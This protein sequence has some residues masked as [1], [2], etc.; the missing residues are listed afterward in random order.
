[1]AYRRAD[2]WLP[3]ARQ[4][5]LGQTCPS[6]EQLM[7]ITDV[8]DPCQNPSAAAGIGPVAPNVGG[9]FTCFNSQTGTYYGCNTSG[10][11]TSVSPSGIGPNGA[12]P[13]NV[14]TFNWGLLAAVVVGV[15][16]F[17]SAVGK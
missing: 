13:L 1:M 2:T 15:V 11:E 5:G 12:P 4:M 10:V 6:M 17:A 8:N 9:S 14:S 16:V 7:G 3:T